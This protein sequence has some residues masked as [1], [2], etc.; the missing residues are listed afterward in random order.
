MNIKNI[1]NR[2]FIMRHGES[3]ANIKKI[4]VSNPEKGVLD[5]G[6][7]DTGKT[8]VLQSTQNFKINNVI[9]FSSDFLRT[10]ETAKIAGSV[11]NAIQIIPTDKL[12]E[13]FFGNFDMSDN[14]NYQRVWSEDRKDPYKKIDNVESVAEVLERMLSQISV[15]ENTFSG[16]NILLVSHGDPLQILSTCFSGLNPGNHREILNLELAEIRKLAFC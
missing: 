12:R 6:L 4:I 3:H 16:M 10:L 13:R 1:N 11:L 2:Y 5:Y 9:I 8:Q 15:I 7:T 14:S